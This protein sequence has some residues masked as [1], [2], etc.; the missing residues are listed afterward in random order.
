MKMLQKVLK[1]YKPLQI[2]KLF[3]LKETIVDGISFLYKYNTP[4]KFS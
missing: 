2:I 3:I 1:T 4:K